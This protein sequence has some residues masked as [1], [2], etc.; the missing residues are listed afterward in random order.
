MYWLRRVKKLRHH[1]GTVTINYREQNKV[2]DHL[3]KDGLGLMEKKEFSRARD[4]SSDIQ[5]L[6]FLDKIGIPTFRS[7]L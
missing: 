6:L 5:K 7:P 1:F 4:L 2:A 3:A